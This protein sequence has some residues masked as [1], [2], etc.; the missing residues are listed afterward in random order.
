MKTLVYLNYTR[1]FRSNIYS[2]EML[3]RARIS[4]KPEKKYKQL[5]K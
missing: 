2:K 4:I 3:N 5:Q 1:K